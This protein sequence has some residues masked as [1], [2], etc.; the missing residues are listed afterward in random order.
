[1][2]P[3]P[4]DPSETPREPDT[5]PDDR[6]NPPAPQAPPDTSDHPS[7]EEA[8]GGQGAE[9]P[10]ELADEDRYRRGPGW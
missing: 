6:G 7:H 2:E 8:V 3:E 4:P 1:M 5:E 10:A 9:D